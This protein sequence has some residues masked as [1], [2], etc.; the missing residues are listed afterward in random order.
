MIHVVPVNDTRPH[1]DS[2]ACWCHPSVDFDL[3]EP[4]AVHN[5]DDGREYVEQANAIVD[6]PANNVD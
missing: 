2:S 1:E 6:G 5:S 4:V 3:P